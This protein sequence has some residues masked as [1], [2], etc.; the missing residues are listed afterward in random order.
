MSEQDLVRGPVAMSFP[1]SG[2][3]SSGDGI[4]ATL[5]EARHVGVL[6]QVLPDQAVGVLVGA[7]LPGVMRIGEVERH[8]GGVLDSGIAVELG[9][10][11][12]GDGLELPRMP[13]DQGNGPGRGLFL[14]A[15]L[16]LA[17]LQVAALALH[18]AHDA[19]A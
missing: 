17:D 6:G 14:S 18:Q 2:V 11:V 5:G 1:W 15:C 9:A 8:A 7:A 13:A 12:G 16:E 10:V 19:V 4:A 3:E